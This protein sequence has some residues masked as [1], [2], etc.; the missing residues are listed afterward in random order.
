[1]T[2]PGSHLDDGQLSELLIRAKARDE[3]AFE[4]LYGEFANRAYRYVYGRTGQADLAEDITAEVFAGLVDGLQTYRVPDQDVLPRF[5]GWFYR[6]VHN[7][8]VDW[9]RKQRREEELEEGTA[10]GAAVSRS[11]ERTLLREELGQAL[12]Q[13]TEEQ[14]QVIVLRFY[15]E[16]SLA[17]VAELMEKSVEAVK[18]LQKRALAA[19]G[20]E[21]AQAG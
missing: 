12:T 19:L 16:L 4:R 20:R 21:L 5:T 9:L 2:H 11:L 18:G 8:M 17:E 13:L 10:V 14:R 7:R 6:V 15:E 1:M 3:A